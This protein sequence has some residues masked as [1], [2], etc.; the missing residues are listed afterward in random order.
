[1]ENA[2]KGYEEYRYGGIP[3][4]D[5]DFNEVVKVANKLGRTSSLRGSSGVGR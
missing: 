1:M 2:L 4:P 3:L 5:L